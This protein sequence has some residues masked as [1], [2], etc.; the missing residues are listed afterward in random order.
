MR[1][2]APWRAIDREADRRSG[3][4]G[5]E[6]RRRDV[7]AEEEAHHRRQLDVAEAHPA[8]VG[9]GGEEEGPP[10]AAAAIARSGRLAGSVAAAIATPS[11]AA[12]S[13]DLV[14]DDPPLEVGQ[15][16]RN[17]RGDEDEAE[18]DF[19]RVVPEDHHGRRVEQA[20]AS[21]VSG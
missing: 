2:A 10:A 21:S 3:E 15:G 8:R 19:R 14:R 18:R 5:D 9:E 16:D 17:E 12:T 1:A 13:E 11:T 20:Q 7:A 6:D 4:Q